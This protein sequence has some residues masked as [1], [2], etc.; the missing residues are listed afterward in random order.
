MIQIFYTE[1]NV[2]QVVEPALHARKVLPQPAS[3]CEPY[4]NQLVSCTKV[5]NVSDNSCLNS[6]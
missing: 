2:T 5:D 3:E 1:V 4:A 6:S